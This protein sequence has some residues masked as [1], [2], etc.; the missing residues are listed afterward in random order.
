[1]ATAPILRKPTSKT[2]II[3]V[4]ILVVLI[5]VGT[6]ILVYN[7]RNKKHNKKVRGGSISRRATLDTL[8][9][10][11]ERNKKEKKTLLD[12]E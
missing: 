6:G 3:V 4:V 7:I 12:Q 2:A 9:E 1:M 10:R 5:V 11:V 8:Q